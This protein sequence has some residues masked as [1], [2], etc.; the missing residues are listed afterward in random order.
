M[1]NKSKDS[2]NPDEVFP[3]I[4]D[5]QRDQ[6]ARLEAKREAIRDQ[7]QANVEAIQRRGLH[8][9]IV[10]KLDHWTALEAAGHEMDRGDK[11]EVRL[12][13]K[14]LAEVREEIEESGQ[15]VEGLAELS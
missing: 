2:L 12:L 11:A 9:R 3:E 8:D 4:T 7:H 5:E 15:S 1:D 14:M 10:V 13:T 6:Q